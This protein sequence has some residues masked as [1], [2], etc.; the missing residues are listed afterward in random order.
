MFTEVERCSWREFS[1]CRL[2]QPK[3]QR[4]KSFLDYLKNMSN[5]ANWLSQT[6]WK[7]RKQL[8]VTD[9]RDEIFAYFTIKYQSSVL[10]LG[11]RIIQKDKMW[12][13]LFE[14]EVYANQNIDQSYK[15][16]FKSYTLKTKSYLDS[17]KAA[18]QS[19]KTLAAIAESNTA[20]VYCF[21]DL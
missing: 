14:A 19:P 13:Y 3:I 1:L 6:F 17:V 21:A 16:E 20:D 12:G 2:F 5:I 7:Q 4:V 9:C 10:E 15:D 8:G 11:Q 18:I